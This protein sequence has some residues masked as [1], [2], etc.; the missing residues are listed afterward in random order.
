MG[1][2]KGNQQYKQIFSVMAIHA[3]IFRGTPIAGRVGIM[4]IVLTLKT[5]SS[6]CLFNK[7]IHFA[8][9]YDPQ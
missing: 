6:S 1:H 8:L 2:K 3:R 4:G 7:N 9:L 5:F